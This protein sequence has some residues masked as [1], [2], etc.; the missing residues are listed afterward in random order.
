MPVKQTYKSRLPRASNSSCSRMFFFGL[1]IADF[2][3]N[4]VERKAKMVLR[5]Q[6]IKPL[7]VDHRRII[8]CL[9]T[10]SLFL[11]LFI[12]PTEARVY[13]PVKL[14]LPSRSPTIIAQTPAYH[15]R[16]TQCR[17][18]DAV[19]VNLRPVSTQRQLRQKN[20]NSLK[21]CLEPRIARWIAYI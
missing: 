14:K 21:N 13:K 15:T 10:L 3:A 19:G 8:F 5:N 18:P 4:V 16:T 17:Y 20:L 12:C 11:I 2:A 9:K 1:T 7:S 6:T